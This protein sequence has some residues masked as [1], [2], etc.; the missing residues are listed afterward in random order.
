MIGHARANYY[1]SISERDGQCNLPERYARHTVLLRQIHWMY[2]SRST[3][4][5]MGMGV[6]GKLVL[7]G[8]CLHYATLDF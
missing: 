7:C 4:S 8:A 5:G 6:E 3:Y 2:H 1:T